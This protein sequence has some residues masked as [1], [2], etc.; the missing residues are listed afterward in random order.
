M[1]GF[2]E[3]LEFLQSQNS[4]PELEEIGGKEHL[5]E[6]FLEAAK[7]T[8]DFYT[9]KEAVF[10]FARF[11]G[12][13]VILSGSGNDRVTA[14]AGH[15][16]IDGG[17]GHDLLRAGK[18]ND[19][20]FGGPGSGRDI[21]LGEEGNDWLVGG[22]GRDLLIGGLG[23]DFLFAG[24]SDDIVIGGTTDHDGSDAA[25]QAILDEWNS[26]ASYLTRVNNI[27][28]GGGS[29]GGIKLE[30][31]ATVHDDGARDRMWGQ[32]GRDWFFADLDGA[33]D[34]DDILGD[35]VP[36]EEVDLF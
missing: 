7:A 13:D 36:N 3:Q 32:Q 26:N 31:N 17:S 16:V 29:L 14:G 21:L 33:D 34:D 11:P 5:E 18:G 4:L 22:A 20:V 30:A 23:N 2:A 8:C 25:L 28:T 24:G 1:L 12:H 6:T 35:K 9:V 10:P 19:L 27:R 15:D